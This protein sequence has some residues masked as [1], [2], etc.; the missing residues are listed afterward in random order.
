[1][2]NDLALT[3]RLAD[4][5]VPLRAI[6]RATKQPS[7]AVREQLHDAKA[8]GH[9][10]ELPK[11]DWPPGFPR[12]RRALQLS[13]MMVENRPVL[14]FSVQKAFGLT[15]SQANLLL[16]LLQNSEIAKENDSNAN[17]LDVHIHHIRKRLRGFGII[18]TT[19]WGY[20]FK[21]SEDARRKTMDLILKSVKSP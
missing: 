3:I 13:R 15:P 11:E 21:L 17:L 14:V 20:G 4:E 10:L 16:R 8:S 7:I 5:G 12:D 19:L 18:V 2:D 6:A 1:M 9:L